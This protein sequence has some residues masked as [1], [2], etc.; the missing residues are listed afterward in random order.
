MVCSLAKQ[1]NVVEQ[2]LHHFEITGTHG[3]VEWSLPSTVPCAVVCLSLYIC[4]TLQEHLTNAGVEPPLY[5]L[6]WVRLLLAREGSVGPPPA[7]EIGSASEFRCGFYSFR[8]GL[9]AIRPPA[10]AGGRRW[11][12][13]AFDASGLLVAADGRGVTEEVEEESEHTRGL[14]RQPAAWRGARL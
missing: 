9:R 3:K 10:F 4:P 2:E 13:D 6:R 12:G 14:M 8:T 7:R 1:G 11:L 5:L